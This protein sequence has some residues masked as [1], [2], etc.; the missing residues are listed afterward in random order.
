LGCE[1]VRE[2]GELKIVDLVMGCTSLGKVR[3]SFIYIGGKCYICPIDIFSPCLL[4]C[5]SSQHIC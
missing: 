5:L 3:Q 1:K 2:F 4:Q